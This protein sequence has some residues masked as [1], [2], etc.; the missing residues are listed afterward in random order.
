MQTAGAA[1]RSSL[2]VA[3]VVTLLGHV[4]AP[5]ELKSDAV[6]LA[7]GS[8]AEASGDNGHQASCETLPR[9][10]VRFSASLGGGT[11]ILACGVPTAESAEVRQAP[12]PIPRLPRFLLFASLLN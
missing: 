9:S 12:S 2:L 6:T 1:L 8:V 7:V 10:S 11:P 5:L 4:C 3:C